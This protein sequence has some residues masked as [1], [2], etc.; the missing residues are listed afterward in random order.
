MRAGNPPG[1]AALHAP[2]LRLCGHRLLVAQSSCIGALALAIGLYAAGIP[3]IWPELRTACE[4]AACYRWQISPHDIAGLSQLTFYAIYKIV[5]EALY[6]VSF[7]LIA[8]I[9]AVRRSKEPMALLAAFALI[10]FGASLSDS[11]RAL[12]VASPGWY[13]P[14][15]ILAFLGWSSLFVCFY[16]FPDGRFVPRW[17]RVAA[18]GWVVFAILHYVS[19][20]A[21]GISSVAPAESRG[22]SGDPVFG[23]G[24]IAF[25][26]SVIFA[27]VYRYRRV[28]TQVQR[29]QTKWVVVGFVAALGGFIAIV[30]WGEHLFSPSNTFTAQLV[31][32]FL[33]NTVVLLLPLSLA[34][35]ILRYRLW[36]IDLI[37]NRALVYGGLSVAVVGLYV[38]VVGYLGALFHTSGNLAFSLVATALVAVLFQPLREWLQRGVN[39]L[40][41]GEQDDP[42]AV[43]SRLGQRLEGTLASDAVLP[44]V[45]ETVTQALKLPYAAVDIGQRGTSTITASAGSPTAE[46]LTLPLTYR[47]ETVGRLLVAPRA[48]ERSFS[49]ADR[50]LLEDLARQAGAAAHAVRLTAEL[51]RSREHLV[52]AREEERRRLRRDLHDGLGPALSGVMLKINTARRLLDLQSPADPVLKEVREDVQRSVADIRRLVYDLR[53]PALDELGLVGAIREAALACETDGRHVI[54]E[55][56]ECL[57]PLPA[58]VEVAAYRIVQ[59]ALTN[60]VRHAHCRTCT[61]RLSVEDGLQVEIADDGVGLPGER[62]IGVGLASMRERAAELGGTCLVEPI[63]EGGTRVQAHLPLAGG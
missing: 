46:L 21:W 48:G 22:P 53:P 4:G 8:T 40:M 3:V 15:E 51:Q 39:R 20:P 1:A 60:A 26:C 28:S 11:M 49:G 14:R 18:A 6:L 25:F 19:P 13:W 5:L 58:A 23:I 56:P 41:Y 29:Q 31:G 59:E 2:G 10:T 63:P 27:Q 61:V 37:I 57:P 17:T 32:L 55:S 36:D 47:G 33:F 38:I 12:A 9:I 42:Y 7:C 52:T 44:L 50:Q 34:L 30:G 16:V 43:L 45:V 54:V 35:A 62:H 24:L